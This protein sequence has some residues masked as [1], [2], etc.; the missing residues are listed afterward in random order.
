M[1]GA[2]PPLPHMTSWRSK[3]LLCVFLNRVYIPRLLFNNYSK[4]YLYFNVIYSYIYVNSAVSNQRSTFLSFLFRKGVVCSH[5]SC[6]VCVQLFMKCQG[7][8]CS[9][10]RY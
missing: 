8:H 3:G 4:L 2:V 9:L 7:T 1:S 6:Q 10:R 5:V